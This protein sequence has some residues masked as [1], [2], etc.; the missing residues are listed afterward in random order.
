MHYILKQESP[1]IMLI[2][3]IIQIIQQN[4]AK[5]VLNI[6]FYISVSLTFTTFLPVTLLSS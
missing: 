5:I 1:G 6:K 2:I 3:A 4:L